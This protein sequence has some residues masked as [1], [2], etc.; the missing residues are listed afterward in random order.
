MRAAGSLSLS[1]LETALPLPQ[2]HTLHTLLTSL[3]LTLL[4]APVWMIQGALPLLPT[5]GALSAGQSVASLPTEISFHMA[6]AAGITVLQNPSGTL[7]RS[8]V[9]QLANLMDRR[10]N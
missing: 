6:V 7:G 5:C 10:M 4:C 3:Q 1:D 8:L 2:A 9:P